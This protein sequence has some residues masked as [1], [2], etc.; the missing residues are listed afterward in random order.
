[1]SWKDILATRDQAQKLGAQGQVEQAVALVG[2]FLRKHATPVAQVAKPANL[3]AVGLLAGVVATLLQG[4]PDDGAKAAQYQKIW[5][6]FADVP[7]YRVMAAASYVNHL[8]WKQQDPA[9]AEKFGREALEALGD[10]LPP[11]YH[12]A[13]LPLNL[14]RALQRQ[15]KID[16]ALKLASWAPFVYP[17]VLENEAVYALLFEC[18]KAKRDWDGMMRAAKLA[19]ALCQ[20]TEDQIGKATDLCVQACTAK[21]G[22]GLA[23]Q[24]VKSQESADTESPFKHVPLPRFDPEGKID[25]LVAQVSQPVNRP[26]TPTGQRPVP[27]A[28]APAHPPTGAPVPPL[29]TAAA[30]NLHARLNAQ[31]TLGD[32]GNAVADALDEMR[33]ASN[34]KDKFKMAQSLTDVARCF[35]A[36]DLNLLRAN[37]FLE[38]QKTGQGENPL[39]TF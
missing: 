34:S 18:A 29:V 31:L 9:A 12:A 15:G 21:G 1:M 7:A 28:E 39:P 38:Y 30:D 33:E 2:S 16:E 8:L 36:K 14:G 5:A 25:G 24:F 10:E 17:M 32:Y 22:P 23:T 6:D 11:V 35:K 19:F 27:Q 37:R 4:M 3:G 13:V 20:Y 26:A